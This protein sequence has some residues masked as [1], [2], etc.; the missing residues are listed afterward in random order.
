MN[1]LILYGG[2]SAEHEISIRS[3]K[4]VFQNLDRSKYKPVLIKISKK[5]EW[6][7]D[8][9]LVVNNSF[10]KLKDFSDF[11]P[12]DQVLFNPSEGN[13][14]IINDIENIS[15]S[16]DAVF[17]VLHGPN[18]EDGT[19]QGLLK[20]LNLPFVGPSVLG[21]SV[22]MDKE[23]M[24]RILLQAEINIGKYLVGRSGKY[25]DFETVK[26]TLGVPAY[27]KPANMGSSVG[28]SKVETKEQYIP[29]IEFAYQF[30][31]KLVIEANIEGREIECAILGNTNPKSSVPGEIVAQ[32]DFYDYKS[33]YLDNTAS[34]LIVNAQMDPK[35]KEEL[36]QI[37]IKVFKVL[38]CE[39]MARVDFFLT[40]DNEIIVNEINTIPGFT[41]ISMYPKLWL[42][43]GIS[44]KELISDLINLAVERFDREKKLKTSL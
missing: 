6:L 17:P 21:S 11:Y 42:G 36:Q 4:N 1:I 22:G 5:G 15:F 20:I 23:I 34:E 10:Y 14:F 12:M 33:K 3:A 44:Y 9:S 31:S 19:I 40:N 28:I 39:G 29:A 25:P 32:K 27:V 24:K 26:N 30:D 8:K 38:E 16:V 13:P 43:T 35:I 41:S 7:T 37:G 18:G 2:K